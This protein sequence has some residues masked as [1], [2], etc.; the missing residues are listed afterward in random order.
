VERV[1]TF[2]VEVTLPPAGG[3][4]GVFAIPQVTVGVEGETEQASETAEL[5]PFREFTL[6]V[7]LVLDPAEVV[8]AGGVIERLKSLTVIE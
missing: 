1:V 6:I 3:V 8:A 7:A 4:T 5:N 2:N